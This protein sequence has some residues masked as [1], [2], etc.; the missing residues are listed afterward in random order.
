MFRAGGGGGGCVRERR[1]GRREVRQRERWPG[2]GAACPPALGEHSAERGRGRGRRG[3]RAGGWARGGRA[4]REPGAG[5]QRAVLRGPRKVEARGEESGKDFC[6]IN[7]ALRCFVFNLV[8]CR[9]YFFYKC[10]H[11]F[12]LIKGGGNLPRNF[13]LY[14]R[15]D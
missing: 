8:L 2:R 7:F 4:E 10:S 5:Q 15:R 11:S 1:E 12:F 9:G 13:S 3:G 6:L 14:G